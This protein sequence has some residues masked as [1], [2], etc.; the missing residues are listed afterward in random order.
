M[1]SDEFLEH[2]LAAVDLNVDVRPI[3]GDAYIGIL[4]A[5]EGGMYGISTSRRSRNDDGTPHVDFVPEV[6]GCK[7]ERVADRFDQALLRR[8]I[9]NDEDGGLGGDS[10]TH[11]AIVLSKLGLA[12][13]PSP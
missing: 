11:A 4:R 1:R 8:L 7:A 13:P 6:E 10:V 5:Y 3:S 12:P 9:L 2:Y